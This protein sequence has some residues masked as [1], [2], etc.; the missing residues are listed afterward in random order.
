MGLSTGLLTGRAAGF[1]RERWRLRHT[2]TDAR[3][4]RRDARTH[5][6]CLLSSCTAG[7]KWKTKRG[8]GSLSRCSRAAVPP[9][10][11]CFPSGFLRMALE[12]SPA[13]KGLTAPR[14]CPLGQGDSTSFCRP[15]PSSVTCP[16]RGLCGRHRCP[17]RIAGQESS[18][19]PE[20]ELSI[21]AAGTRI[22]GSPC[23]GAYVLLARARGD[24]RC[25]GRLAVHL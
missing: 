17:L 1:P 11:A 25:Q 6:P 19:L 14:P 22:L 3:A 4:H 10:L 20:Q 7:K 13:D 8:T 21:Q 9:S 18:A 5:C 2:H 16:C 12:S 23:F 15:F 24:G